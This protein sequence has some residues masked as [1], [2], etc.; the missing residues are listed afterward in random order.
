MSISGATIAVG[1]DRE[2]SAAT[3]VNGNQASND[4]TDSGAA[5][6][7]RGAEGADPPP[8]PGPWL[9]T[10]GLPGLRFK[11]VID[12]DRTGTQVTDC[13]PQTLC[14]AGAIPTRAEL[15]VRIIGPRP[16]GKLWAQAVRFTVSRVELWVEQTSSGEINYY[17][18]PSLSASTAV[19]PGVDDSLAF[20]P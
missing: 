13:V 15:F 7:F 8:P 5:Y 3:G 1:A 6:V 18:L 19:L 10:P 12:G 17:E 4:Y 9:S 14:I 2:D 11:V 16:N 20:D